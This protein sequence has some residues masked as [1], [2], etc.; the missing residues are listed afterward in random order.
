[1]K[2]LFLCFTLFCFTAFLL[3]CGKD[4]DTNDTDKDIRPVSDTPYI[5]LIDV[6]P[7]NVKA[8]EDSIVFTIYYLDGNGDIGTSDADVN[9]LFLK[10]SRGAFEIGYHI[11]PLSPKN[12]SITIE[13]HFKITLQ[14]TILFGD[15][16]SA[17]KAVFE[18]YLVDKAGLKSNVLHSPEI[19]VNP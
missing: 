6:Q 1:M 16:E 13:G 17:E 10:D 5:E 3:S 18:I 11:P 12:S 8:F 19:T 14:N 15:G 2:N 4:N 9:S 7:T